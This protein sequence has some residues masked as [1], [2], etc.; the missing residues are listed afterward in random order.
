LFRDL[1]A[2]SKRELLHAPGER[3]L[4]HAPRTGT[5]SA[6]LLMAKIDD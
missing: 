6:R 1:P 5:R 2:R 4:L 3:E